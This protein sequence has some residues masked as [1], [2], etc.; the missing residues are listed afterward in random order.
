MG[1]R[2]KKRCAERD[3]H[4][5]CVD[6]H[7][8]DECLVEPDELNDYNNGEYDDGHSDDDCDDGR[9]LLQSGNRRC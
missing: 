6:N 4:D 5:K 2:A 3:L 8:Y 1:C 9:S 7:Q